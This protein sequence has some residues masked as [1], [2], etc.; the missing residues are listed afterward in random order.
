MF[1]LLSK[2]CGIFLE[3]YFHFCLT[4]NN[5]ERV[6]FVFT[7]QDCFLYLLFQKSMKFQDGHYLTH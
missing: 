6:P 2:V 1:F 7:E 5:N 3:L 4:V